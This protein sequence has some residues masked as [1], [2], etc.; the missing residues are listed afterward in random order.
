[1]GSADDLDP[2]M[3]K[4]IEEIFSDEI[5]PI[6]DGIFI[7][8][9]FFGNGQHLRAQMSIKFIDSIFSI[10]VG[11]NIDFFVEDYHSSIHIE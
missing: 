11:Q 1:M 7:V 9:D 5:A 4:D 8:S 6:A 3:R 10:L 2:P